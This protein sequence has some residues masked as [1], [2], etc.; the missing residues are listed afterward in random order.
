M[1][2]LPHWGF[3]RPENNPVG[4]FQRERAG[5]PPE[6]AERSEAEEVLHGWLCACLGA[7]A[8]DAAQ[9]DLFRL[10][11]S[12][13]STFPRGEGLETTSFVSPPGKSHIPR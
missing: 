11:A 8:R 2:S 1:P 5:R 4:C 10:V 9:G 12:L 13:R 6:G 3:E 7:E